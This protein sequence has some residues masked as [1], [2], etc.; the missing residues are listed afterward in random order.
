MKSPEQRET[1][2]RN[3]R[4]VWEALLAPDWT[5]DDLINLGKAIFARTPLKRF[6]P[7]KFDRIL[8]HLD[9]ATEVLEAK[10]SPLPA[11]PLEP[12]GDSHPGVE[13]TGPGGPDTSPV[14]AHPVRGATGPAGP[15]VSPDDAR[16][17]R[18]PTGPAASPDSRP[19]TR[20][21]HPEGPRGQRGPGP[22]TTGPAGPGVRTQKG[23]E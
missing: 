22:C 23:G 21:S 15:D 2:A 19:A 10:I 13:P 7:D 8:P 11:D 17:G 9:K 1:R 16:L 4:A 5:K 20:D 18:G 14:E 12:T 3:I 6:D